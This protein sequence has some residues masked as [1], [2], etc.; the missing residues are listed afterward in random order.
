MNFNPKTGFSEQDY[1]LLKS[2]VAGA[3]GATKPYEFYETISITSSTPQW[4]K[5]LDDALDDFLV[6]IYLPSLGSSY[7][8]ENLNLCMRGTNSTLTKYVAIQGSKTTATSHAI[9]FKNTEGV[10]EL[11][12]NK[13]CTGE[14]GVATQ[15]GWVAKTTAS[16]LETS[17][18]S[19]QKLPV[20]TLQLTGAD[21]IPAGTVVVILKR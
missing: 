18:Q 7:P 9:S 17:Y 10:F 21:D 14:I 5:T 1:Q 12:Y 4:D 6:F 16:G 20:K 8:S 15:I 11:S 13:P 2:A 19:F 3:G